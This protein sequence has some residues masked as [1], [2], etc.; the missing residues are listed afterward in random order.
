[1]LSQFQAHTHTHTQTHVR[2]HKHMLTHTHSQAH[3][4]T[5]THT[6]THTHTQCT[7]TN[8]LKPD[9]G[10]SLTHMLHSRS[11]NYIAGPFLP[12][13]QNWAC[14]D[15]SSPLLS[16]NPSPPL[17]PPLDP[18]QTTQADIPVYLFHFLFNPPSVPACP[19]VQKTRSKKHCWDFLIWLLWV[20]SP[21]KGAEL[22]RELWERSTPGPSL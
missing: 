11:V 14:S 7:Y 9:T 22:R 16:S 20:K 13:N 8:R 6:H 12:P 15:C 3:A 18:I 19:G 17:D 5:R 4:D 10:A 21:R 2:T 1:M